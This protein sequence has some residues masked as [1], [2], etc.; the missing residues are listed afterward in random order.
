MY[1]MFDLF[2]DTQ[3]YTPVYVIPDSEMK[4]LQRTQNQE[5]I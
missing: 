3:T 5:E 2:F 4:D 1:S